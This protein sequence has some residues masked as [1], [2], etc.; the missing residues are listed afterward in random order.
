MTT[1]RILALIFLSTFI[2]FIGNV[3]A[4]K[5][6]Y[7]FEKEDPITGEI[8]RGIN[9]PLI[10]T[11]PIN[12]TTMWYLGIN[13]VG[14]KY[15]FGMMAQ[16]NGEMNVALHKNDSI[17]FKFADG[18][19]KTI[20]ANSET[21]PKTN[22]FVYAGQP[23]ITTQYRCNYDIS[24]TDL[25]KFTESEIVFIRMYLADTKME[26]EL[27]PKQGKKFKQSFICIMN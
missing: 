14:V 8:T 17:I 25:K 2:S 16:F 9:I 18:S 1:K 13:K 22:A 27:K 15:N 20:H 11:S 3:N 23:V 7:D 26:K 21:S 6:K 4:Q 12:M 5:C 24:E 10:K 19:F